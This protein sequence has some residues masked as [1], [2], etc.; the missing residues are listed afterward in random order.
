MIPYVLYRGL[1]MSTIERMTITLPA[2]MAATLRQMVAGDESGPGIP[3]GEVFAELR[4]LI[5]ERRA[6]G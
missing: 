4:A 5:V 1:S 2:E 3:V 6:R